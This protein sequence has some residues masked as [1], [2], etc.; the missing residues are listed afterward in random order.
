MNLTN[1]ANIISLRVSVDYPAMWNLRAPDDVMKLME[2]AAMRGYLK[3]HTDGHDAATEYAS[4]LIA[5][6]RA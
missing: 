6:V 5:K 3:G 4:N 1:L 2:I